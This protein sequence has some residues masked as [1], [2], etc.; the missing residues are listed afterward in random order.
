MC[1]YQQRS[2]GMGRNRKTFTLSKYQ[3]VSPETDPENTQP[4]D[5][6]DKYFMTQFKYG[7]GAKEYQENN[8]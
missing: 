7:Q 5:L 8:I 3:N 1:N 4:A 2:Q 6:A